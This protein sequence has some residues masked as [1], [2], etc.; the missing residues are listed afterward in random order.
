MMYMLI[1]RTRK[2]LSSEQYQ[3]LGKLAQDFYDNI[4]EGVI[5]HSDWAANDHSCT[6]ALLESENPQLIDQIQQ[7]CQ[8]ICRY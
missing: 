7:P 2:N 1:S 4:P 6:F 3:Q 5:L 8:G